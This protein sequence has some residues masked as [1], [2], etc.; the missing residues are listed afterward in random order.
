MLCSVARETHVAEVLGNPFVMGFGISPAARLAARVRM[1]LTATGVVGMLVDLVVGLPRW[2]SLPSFAALLVGLVLYLRAGTPRG[3]V[4]DLASP[5]RGRWQVVNSPSTR[6]PSHGVHGWSQTYAVDLVFDPVDGHRP[7]WGWWPAARRPEEFPGF[8][9]PVLSPVDGDVVRV[10][11]AARDHWSRTS[12]PA[13]AYLVLEGVRELLGPPGVVGNHVVVRR[14][15]GLCVLLAH[16]RRGSALVSVGD[17]V[18]AGQQLADC[19]NSGNSTEPH[20]HLQAMDKPS[21]WVAAGL[22]FTLEGRELPRSG[23]ALERP[24]A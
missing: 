13:L 3:D 10:F 12:P 16:L 23:E 21:P 6:V 22:P 5:V 20:L 7:G 15:D 8:G 24:A 17:R 2:V 11:T 1:P 9:Q 18:T 19:G 4:V 14:D